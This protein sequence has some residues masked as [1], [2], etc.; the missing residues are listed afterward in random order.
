MS[1]MLSDQIHALFAGLLSKWRFRAIRT[2]PIRRA[3]QLD[4]MR[5]SR[6]GLFESHGKA[7]FVCLP[8]SSSA[9]A[10]SR[11]AAQGHPVNPGRDFWGG[12]LSVTFLGRARKVTSRR[13]APGLLFVVANNPVIADLSR[14]A[15]RRELKRNV[16]H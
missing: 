9:V 4:S 8:R 7:R 5:G 10:S 15:Q 2:S 12:L 14:A 6:R 1:D 13:A 11:Q 16:R 3:E